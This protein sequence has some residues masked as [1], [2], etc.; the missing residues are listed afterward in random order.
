MN[1]VSAIVEH[2]LPSRIDALDALRRED[3]TA[4]QLREAAVATSGTAQRLG[5]VAGAKDWRALATGLETMAFLTDWS[6]AVD[7][8][9]TDADRH[10]RAARQRLKRLG[11]EEEPSDFQRRVADCLA[12]I[13]GDFEPDQ[14]KD[15]R[16]RLGTIAMPVAILADPEPARHSFP[17]DEPAAAV[18][19]LTVAFLEF[20]INGAPAANLHALIP[21]EIHDLGLVIRASRW[22]ESA[23]TLEITPVSVEP[24]SAWDLPSFLF[25]KPTGDPPYTFQRDQRMVI[26]ASQSFDA[27]PLEFLYAAQFHPR[28]SGEKIVVAG[29]RRLRLDGLGP[30]GHAVSGYLELDQSILEV[31]RA[32]RSD[33][34]IPEGDIRNVMKLLP[35]LANLAGAS[36]QDALY[37]EPIVESVFE[38][39]VR[40]R[41]RA[42]PS[43][44]SDLEQQAQA[45]GGR[46]DL[47][48]HGVRL[49]LKSV[50]KKRLLPEDCL[51]FAEQTAMYAVGSGKRV[52]ILCILDCSPK[53]T[54]PLPLG[55]CLFI[56][57]HD[58]GAGSVSVIVVLV[59]GG[60]PKPSQFS[61]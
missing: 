18:D 48:F 20:T 32:L 21:N 51:K 58:T 56:H 30:N 34:A 45:A 61:R 52:A 8:A 22:P 25:T 50:R 3:V 29:Q 55:S 17:Y 14:V 16:L 2:A 40:D 57:Q 26:H 4:D 36:V 44:G 46:T 33:T 1:S 24:R 59:Q 10:L 42:V 12:V 23:E 49:E 54:T 35:H 38:T 13:A 19:D 39:D 28:P 15:L 41:L 7:T 6:V 27:R 11:N 37:P 9:G 31:R 47:S 53:T 5:R 43:I 60:F